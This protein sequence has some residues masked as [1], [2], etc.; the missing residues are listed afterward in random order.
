ME[1]R[2]LQKDDA[3]SYQNIRLE[4]LKNHPFY[5]AASY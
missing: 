2:L 1:I 4:G 3:E 5:F